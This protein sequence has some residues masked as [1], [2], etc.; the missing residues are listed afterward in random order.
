MKN[1]LNLGFIALLLVVLGCSCPSLKDLNP[2]ENRSSPPPPPP[3]PPASTPYRTNTSTSPT[4]SGNA[5]LTLTKY[6]QVKNGMSYK[7]VVDILGSEGI[8]V[9]STGSGKFKTVTYRWIGE[10][11]SYIMVTIENDKLVIKSQN[12]MK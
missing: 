3:P 1:S 11:N 2:G 4:K 9:T 8:V 7:Q 10:N 12:G 5:S 6:N